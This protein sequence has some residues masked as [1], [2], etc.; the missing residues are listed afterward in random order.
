MSPNW[1]AIVQTIFFTNSATKQWGFITF[2]RGAKEN[3]RTSRL[4]WR[5]FSFSAQIRCC[6]ARSAR[7]FSCETSRQPITGVQPPAAL[8]LASFSP[9]SISRNI[10]VTLHKTAILEKAKDLDILGA[11]VWQLSEGKRLKK[12]ASFGWI[13]FN[14]SWRLTIL[15]FRAISSSSSFFLHSKWASIRAWSS[16]RSLFWRFFWMSCRGR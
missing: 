8:S 5:S 3:I 9:A 12:L 7:R 6:S 10:F 16:I 13:S 1:K 14:S 2:R 11:R 15:S 4:A